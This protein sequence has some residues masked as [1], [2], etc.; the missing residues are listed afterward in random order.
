MTHVLAIN[1]LPVFGK[2]AGGVT[3]PIF[4]YLGLKT[5]LLPTCVLPTHLGY[6]DST[7]YVETDLLKT[8][9]AHSK[10]LNDPVDHVVV[11]FVPTAEQA[12]I[13]TKYLEEKPLPLYFDPTIGDNG[14]YYRYFQTDFAKALVPL[15]KVADYLTPNITEACLLTDTDYPVFSQKITVS[16]LKELAQKLL[17][18]NPSAKW[19]VS[20][21]EL[22]ESVIEVWV[23]SQG[24]EQ[25]LIKR[26]RENYV[27]QKSVGVGDCFSQIVFGLLINHYSLEVA[28]P[29]AM[30]FIK[31]SLQLTTDPFEGLTYEP[32][33]QKLLPYRRFPINEEVSEPYQ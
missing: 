7:L 25:P 15:A 10:K 16:F 2:V 19:I 3:Y 31:E 27:M 21:I 24:R 17:E 1:D 30:A 5:A 9:L 18:L 26:F 29:V 23:I 8:S 14:H 32:L 6:K 28:I 11:G 4:S 22:E 33:F 12:E 20:G 13:I